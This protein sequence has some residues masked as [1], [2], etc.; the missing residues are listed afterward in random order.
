M[1]PRWRQPWPAAQTVQVCRAAP[2]STV[3][4]VHLDSLD[5]GTVTRQSLRAY[6]ETH[7]IRP[8]D[9]NSTTAHYEIAFDDILVDWK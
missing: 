3:V 2:G 7:G 8:A 6:A 1:Q 5:H 4:A 9:T